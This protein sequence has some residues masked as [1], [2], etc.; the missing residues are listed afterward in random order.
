MVHYWTPKKVW[1]S[2]LR[3]LEHILFG[4]KIILFECFELYNYAKLNS[5]FNW[6]DKIRLRI[7][8][9]SV[10]V[11]IFYIHQYHV[12]CSAVYSLVGCSSVMYDLNVALHNCTQ[13]L[14][15][16]HPIRRRVIPRWLCLCKTNVYTRVP[17][18]I[19]FWKLPIKIKKCCG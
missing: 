5:P 8:L 10:M 7:I 12:H 17:R 19:L 6:T 2:R 4:G 11:Y 13:S 1:G 16:G 3:R 9:R 15:L 18:P 14:G